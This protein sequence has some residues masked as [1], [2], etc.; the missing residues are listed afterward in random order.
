M[1][2]GVSDIF[3]CS[4]VELPKIHNAAGNITIIQNGEDYPFDVRRVYYL[5]DVPGGSER[6][7]H[8]HR[9]L[10][11][12]I[13]A[14]GGSFDVVLDDG[15]NKKVVEL[16]RPYFALYVMPGI[17]R[18]IINFSSGAICLVLASEKF[19]QGD[20]IRDYQE[21]IKFREEIKTSRNNIF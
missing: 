21:F 2:K 16:N 11:Q 5:Y 9:N 1:R 6:G 13:I 19:D 3:N 4:V 20:Y 14:A 10:E 7:G 17:W 8:A 18:E 12:L 15:R